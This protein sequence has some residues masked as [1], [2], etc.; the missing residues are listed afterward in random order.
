[1]HRR[2]LAGLAIA[3][4][5]IVACVDVPDNMR[6]QFA[7]PTPDDRT[8]YRPGHHGMA[9]AADPVIDAGMPD[10]APPPAPETADG[11]NS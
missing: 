8:N 9:P 3:A 2:T 7:G 6:A 5:G 11:G 1:M 10:V 4:L